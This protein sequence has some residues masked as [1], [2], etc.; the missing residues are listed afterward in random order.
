MFEKIKKIILNYSLKVN[1]PVFGIHLIEIIH[2]P[3]TKLFNFNKNIF[4]QDN[5]YIKNSILEKKELEKL[6][7]ICQQIFDKKKKMIN[8]ISLDANKSYF[9]NIL[10][11]LDI[12]NNLFLKEFANAP[13]L[14]KHVGD[15]LGK[16]TI[17]SFG[18][19]Y[20]KKSKDID[21]SQLWHVDGDSSKQ[22]K[23][24]VNINKVTSKNGPFE[25][26]EKKIMN[27][28]LK[29][30]G[31]LKVINDK[32]VEKFLCRDKKVTFVGMPGENLLVDTSNCLHQG[33]RVESG[34]RLMFTIQYLPIS[35]AI[36][37]KETKSKIGRSSI[38]N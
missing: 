15:Y 28:N 16:F 18:L 17:H 9:F 24:F 22:L 38:Y 20:S 35:N 29:N 8:K 23:L 19:F 27:F 37:K 10:N 36:I 30:R 21:G 34:Y 5:G 11:D 7:F 12:E 25:F 33:S 31:L 32:Y 3:K 6:V 14:N 13:S 4:W 26:F 2:N 1:L